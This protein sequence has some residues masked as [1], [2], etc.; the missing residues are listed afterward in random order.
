MRT[1][2]SAPDMA[3][4]GSASNPNN[5][6]NQTMDASDIDPGGAEHGGCASSV[7][8]PYVTASINGGSPQ[9]FTDTSKVITGCQASTASPYNESTQWAQIS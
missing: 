1:E 5:L 3:C 8:A 2:G 4:T 9:T 7:Q 6:G